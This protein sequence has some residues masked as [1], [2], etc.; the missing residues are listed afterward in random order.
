MLHFD[1][2]KIYIYVENI[3]W[4]GEIAYNNIWHLFFILNAL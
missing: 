1:A 2:L 3:M 4:K